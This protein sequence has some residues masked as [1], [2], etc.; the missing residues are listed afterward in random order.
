MERKIG[1]IYSSVDGQTQKICKELLEFFNQKQIETELYSI[2]SFN[3]DLLEFHTI[4]IGASVRYGKHKDKVYDF[5]I[6]N[7]DYLN[8]ITT[9]FFSVNLV[10]RKEDKNSAS[11]NPYLI[12]FLKKTKWVPNFSDVFAGKLDYKS[13][14]LIDNLMIKLIMKLTNGPIKSNLP[15]EFTKWQRVDNFGQRIINNYKNNEK[16]EI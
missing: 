14:S 1:I 10:A 2:D 13:Y 9:A 16:E 8:K 4:I 7:I 15:I 6:N 5:I 11:T 3:G 12:K